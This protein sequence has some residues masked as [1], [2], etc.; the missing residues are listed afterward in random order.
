M[1]FI[2]A[3]CGLEEGGGSSYPAG[4]GTPWNLPR[5]TEP[6]RFSDTGVGWGV[7]TGCFLNGTLQQ[8]I[9]PAAL[10]ASGDSFPLIVLNTMEETW[11]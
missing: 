4:S 6:F 2:P 5:S 9:L 3:A 11:G 8:G 1:D 7:R 10:V